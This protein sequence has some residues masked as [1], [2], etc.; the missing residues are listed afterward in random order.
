MASTKLLLSSIF[1]PSDSDQSEPESPRNE[2]NVSDDS[3]SEKSLNF[4]CPSENESLV[5]HNTFEDELSPDDGNS[6][7]GSKCSSES[8]QATPTSSANKRGRGRGRGRGRARSSGNGGRSTPS[9]TRK[10]RG[11]AEEDSWLVSEPSVIKLNIPSYQ[12]PDQGELIL[13]LRFCVCE[14]AHETNESRRFS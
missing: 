2:E 5:L 10:D 8:L 7:D 4:D 6:S 11:K 9:H 13:D 1:G 12:G 14:K 3:S